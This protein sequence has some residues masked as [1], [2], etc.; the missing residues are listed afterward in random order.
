MCRCRCKH[1]GRFSWRSSVTLLVSQD[2]GPIVVGLSRDIGRKP[3]I[4]GDHC[5]ENPPD[6]L[7]AT[8]DWLIGGLAVWLGIDACSGNSRHGGRF[9]CQ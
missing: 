5:F 2:V 4:S 8:L 3:T 6:A 7:L 1:L 9:S